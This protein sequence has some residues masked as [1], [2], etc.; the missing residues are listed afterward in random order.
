[1]QYYY[2]ELKDLLERMG[3]EGTKIPT[4]QSFQIQVLKKYFYGNFHGSQRTFKQLLILPVFTSGLLIFGVMISK[5]SD[6]GDGSYYS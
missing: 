6:A 4:L 2:Y 5:D 1:M 3:Y